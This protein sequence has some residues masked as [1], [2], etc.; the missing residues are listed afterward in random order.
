MSRTAL[1]VGA[2]A[3]ISASF[4]RLLAGEGYKIALASRNPAK[5]AALAAHLEATTHVC[6][7][8]NPASVDELFA[9]IDR[10]FPKLDVCLFNASALG[11][12][13]HREPVPRPLGSSPRPG[14]ARESLEELAQA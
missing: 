11:R 3:G 1:I 14:A 6:D 5:V 13:A 2:G 9:Q 4:A 8:A 7:A 10:Q 12:R